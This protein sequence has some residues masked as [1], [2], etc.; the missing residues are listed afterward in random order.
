MQCYLTQITTRTG[1]GKATL[2][3]AAATTYLYVPASVVF[4][5]QNALEY[6]VE[7]LHKDA[8]PHTSKLLHLLLTVCVNK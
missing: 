7:Q 1:H 5:S 2:T 8:E 6:G 3:T 4:I